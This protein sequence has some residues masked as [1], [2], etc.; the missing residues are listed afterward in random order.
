MA[1]IRR[2]LPN[3]TLAPCFFTSSTRSF[4]SDHNAAHRWSEAGPHD[5]K[6]TN[7]YCIM[8]NKVK[9]IPAIVRDEI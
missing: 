9:T 3:V 7:H 4:Q 1:D 6:P 2:N 5:M 8:D